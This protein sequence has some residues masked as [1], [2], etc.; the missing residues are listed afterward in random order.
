MVLQT[1][2]KAF[3]AEKQLQKAQAPKVTYHFLKVYKDSCLK[4]QALE[5]LMI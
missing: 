1:K 5:S 2:T 3:Q 4:I